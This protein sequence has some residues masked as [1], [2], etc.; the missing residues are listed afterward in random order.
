MDASVQ[1]LSFLHNVRLFKGVETQTIQKFANNAVPR[2]LNKGSM[3]CFPEDQADHFFVMRNG[4]IK[5]SRSSVDGQ[6]AV[7]DILTR[8][9]VF[10]ETALFG[11]GAYGWSAE[12]VEDAD[13]LALPSKLLR[14]YV[15][16]DPILA[17][18][19]ITSMTKIRKRQDGEIERFILQ[20]A[21]QRVGCFLLKLV[22][23]DVVEEGLPCPAI[24]LPFNKSLLATKLGMT[25]ETFSRALKTLKNNAGLKIQ[26]VTVQINDIN[27]LDKYVCRSC[28]NSYPCE[29]VE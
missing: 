28:S 2:S 19:L 4:W 5:L 20:N 29:H 1:T 25:P 12:V 17:V 14:T 8:N 24:D 22:P 16:K 18:N 27:S 3:L 7:L 21:P 13:F 9:S 23:T 26:G 10:G 15:E 6:E 11:D